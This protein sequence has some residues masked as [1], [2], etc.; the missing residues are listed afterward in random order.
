MNH[1]LIGGS[2]FIGSMISRALINRGDTV[3]SISKSGD[4]SVSGVTSVAVDL[5]T[6]RCP[7]ELLTVADTVIVLIGQTHSDFD[8]ELEKQTL[9]QLANQLKDGQ[10]RVY[11]ASTTLVYGDATT[12]ASEST[13][14]RPI[15]A[16]S[17][18]KVEAEAIL[19][20]TI[21]SDRLTIF[22]F[23]N[24]YGA[25][26]NRG[27]IGLLMQKSNEASI[28][29][30]L[31]DDGLQTRDYIFVDDLVSSILHIV[32][33]PNESGITNVATGTTH[34]LIKVVDEVS[35][36]LGRPIEYTVTHT[37]IEEPHDNRIDTHRLQSV[38]GVTKFTPLAAGLAI[39]YSRYKDA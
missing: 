1:V 20:A 27:I 25:P 3:T 23:A 5:Y 21:P 28:T 18:F 12:P 29:V 7:D 36:V 38:F 35:N 11:Y 13:P 24:V 14:T 22:R 30:S 31:N 37:P 26:K 16:Y 39:T 17:T 6:T 34:T 15:G 4:D 10:S 32:D 8:A 2:G 9:Q 33:K 19:R